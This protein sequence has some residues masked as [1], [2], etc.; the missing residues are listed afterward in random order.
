MSRPARSH[1]RSGFT[2]AEVAITIALLTVLALVVMPTIMGR[3]A[4]ARAEALAAELQNI[5]TALATFN[6]STRQY[7]AVLADLSNRRTSGVQ[8]LC[9]G[10][11]IIAN[12]W[13]GPYSSRYYDPNVNTYT[14][15]E[16]DSI[17][18]TL[19]NSRATGGQP[20]AVGVVAITDSATAIEVD[21]RLDGRVNPGGAPPGTP[22]SG[23][24]TWA[25]D[26]SVTTGSWVVLRYWLPILGC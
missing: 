7:P 14:T 18:Q 11:T 8:N 4:K 16:G 22:T 13:R 6:T 9:G 26:P 3:L 20:G 21:L 12:R 1:A 5:G 15:A 23:A 24:V 17:R 10:S 2:L 19:D 25:V